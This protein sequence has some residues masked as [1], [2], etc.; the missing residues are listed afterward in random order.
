[1]D[2]T[3]ERLPGVD[4]RRADDDVP[5]TWDFRV[6]DIAATWAYDSDLK[7]PQRP[8]VRARIAERV[9]AERIGGATSGASRIGELGAN[10]GP[11][12]P[13]IL[14]LGCGPGYL[15]AAILDEVP[16]AAY[17]LLDFSRPFL[18]MARRQAGSY[19]Y[20][21]FVLA[22]F[23]E[24]AWTEGLG[25]FD[26]IVT[27]QAVHELRHKRRAPALYAQ[28]RDLLVPGGL[29]IVCDGAPQT[30]QPLGM[31]AAEQQAALASAGFTDIE[32]VTQIDPL[33]V[34][35]ASRTR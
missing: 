30:E 25:T 15:A 26:A 13:R 1:V 18:A 16:F 10:P 33:Y 24:P 7:K 5:T 8:E 20:T 4:M 19:P 28:V 2:V 32:V 34:V 27:M 23:I 17:T 14:E 21:D 29:L 12:A 9:A 35:C 3:D 22:D 6:P 11:G 31:T